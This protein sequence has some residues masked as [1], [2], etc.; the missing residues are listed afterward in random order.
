MKNVI[1]YLYG[2]EFANQVVKMDNLNLA[3]QNAMN[4]K[5]C[6]M[7]KQELENTL[8]E[9]ERKEHEQKNHRNGY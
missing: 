8:Q 9:I 1:K 5:Y 4:K 3:I 7:F 2:E 6:M